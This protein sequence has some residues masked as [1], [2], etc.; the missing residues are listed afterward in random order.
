MSNTIET[1]PYVTIFAYSIL[2][3]YDTHYIKIPEPYTEFFILFNADWTALP[4]ISHQSALKKTLYV[5]QK[6][7]KF[8]LFSNVHVCNK[9]IVWIIIDLIECHVC[10]IFCAYCFS[11]CWFCEWELVFSRKHKSEF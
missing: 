4:N 3:T 10:N 5:V 8:L 2:F 1:Q 7:F 9:C 6:T 11:K